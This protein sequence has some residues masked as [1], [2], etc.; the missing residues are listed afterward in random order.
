MAGEF[1]FDLT[2]EQVE[3]L[4]AVT[5]RARA[6]GLEVREQEGFRGFWL[7]R[8]FYLFW[9]SWSRDRG[10]PYFKAR[11]TY[12]YDQ[13]EELLPIPL[14]EENRER[15]FFAM[16]AIFAQYSAAKDKARE[17][18]A[19]RRAA[20]RAAN[21]ELPKPLKSPREPKAPQPSTP[22][23]TAPA[24]PPVYP[25]CALA[26]EA[27][28]NLERAV[29]AELHP[30]DESALRCGSILRAQA[31]HLLSQLC[32]LLKNPRVAE[33]WRRY[34]LF[35][36]E[37]YQ[38]IGE[39]HGL[40]RER[41]RQLVD[42]GNK[43]LIARF[44]LLCQ[45]GGDA[46]MQIPMTAMQD[47]L[48]RGGERLIVGFWDAFEEH[49]ERLR[50]FLTRLLFGLPEKNELFYTYR[51]QR[52]ERVKRE[53]QS[54]PPLRFLRLFEKIRYPQKADPEAFEV[55]SL[56]GRF[57]SPMAAWFR[58]MLERHCPHLCFVQDPDMV[59]YTSETTTHRPDFLLYGEDDRPILVLILPTINMGFYYNVKRFEALKR[60]CETRGYGWLIA[61]D[62]GE[63]YE[64]LEVRPV[65][66]EVK[67]ALDA[68]LYGMGEILWSDVCRLKTCMKISNATIVSYVLQGGRRFTLSPFCIR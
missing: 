57:H 36:G 34:V 12:S 47:A 39:D 40:S 32:E 10:T 15:I 60:F 59:Y 56:V 43:H 67:A 17:A 14:A 65:P 29:K 28:A 22:K 7:R 33:M 23:I 19:E 63:T 53:W 49:E 37:T 20:R 18:R 24:A 6:W 48:E 8:R 41:V 38:Q 58:G 31:L 61:T 42:R 64:E 3:I 11:L 21:P 55:R 26:A 5:A 4:E 62:R 52:E 35:G 54:L 2:P 30:L 25:W 13:P 44:A 1:I 27:V 9:L 45:N 16:E 66:D 68:I 50:A 46:Q 51:E